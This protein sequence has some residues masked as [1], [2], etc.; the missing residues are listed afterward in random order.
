MSAGYQIGFEREIAGLHYASDSAA[1]RALGAAIYA[2][3]EANEA[4]QR[5]VTAAKGEWR[6]QGP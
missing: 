3:L 4:F 5:E 2:R 6:C 1:S